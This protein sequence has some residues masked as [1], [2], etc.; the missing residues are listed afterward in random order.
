MT[1]LQMD[2]PLGDRAPPRLLI[3]VERRARPP[4]PWAWMICQEGRA[5]PLR[6]STRCYRSAEDAWTVGRAVLERLPKT[7]D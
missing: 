7:I 6:C 3:K 5:E 2:P 1:K 4:E